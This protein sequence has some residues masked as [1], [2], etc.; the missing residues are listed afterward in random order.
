MKT[1]QM[2]ETQLGSPDGIEVREYEEDETYELPDR[3]ADIFLE[4]RWAEEV[5]PSIDD[6]LEEQV[7]EDEPVDEDE[8]V[9]EDASLPGPPET[10][11]EP[12][13]IETKDELVKLGRPVLNER[14]AAA[15]VV[16]PEKL[17][18]KGAVADA[19]LAAA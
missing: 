8:T 5:T 6:V 18:N 19:I 15:G 13:P 11:P 10:K 12:T 4:Q 16:E 2:L 17:A 9:K 14:A 7:D 3:L 1:I